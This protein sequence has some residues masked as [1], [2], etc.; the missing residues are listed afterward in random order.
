MIERTLEPRDFVIEQCDRPNSVTI[1]FRH[2]APVDSNHVG[3]IEWKF[4]VEV[5]KYYPH[6]PPK[7]K[8]LSLPVAL[9]SG[10][11]F[12]N[13]ADEVQH[14]LLLG[15]WKATSCLKTVIDLLRHV[16]H[17]DSSLHIR[18]DG[19]DEASGMMIA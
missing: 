16:I 2:P 14:P 3:A 7:V 8:Y 18:Q 1:K 15:E 17:D 19:I 12:I 5:S 10:S 9:S 4:L 6:D 13:I 11:R